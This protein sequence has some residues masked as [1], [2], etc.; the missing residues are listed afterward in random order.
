[1]AEPIE[2][3]FVYSDDGTPYDPTHEVGDPCS[4]CDARREA[5]AAWLDEDNEDAGV[6]PPPASTD[7]DT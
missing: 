2:R 7:G 3:R 5:V 6:S 4:V 1:M